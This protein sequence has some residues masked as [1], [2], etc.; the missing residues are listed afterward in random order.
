MVSIRLPN[1]KIIK[2]IPDGTPKEVI[3]QKIVNSG[4]LRAEDNPFQEQQ[5]TSDIFKQQLTGAARD[6]ASFP[7]IIG[8]YADEAEAFAR[9]LVGPETREEELAKIRQ[10]QSQ[11]EDVLERTGASPYR[12]A[13]QIGGSI[14]AGG[15]GLGK[16]G[17]LISKAGP[18]GQAVSKFA[19]T[20]A[21]QSLIGAGIGAIEGAGF[22]DEEAA[23]GGLLG[24]AIGGAVPVVGRGIARAL[25]KTAK[26]AGKPISQ[27]ASTDEGTSA[28]IK[29]IDSSPKLASEIRP[30]AQKGLEE[31]EE[32][33]QRTILDK[34][35]IK[36]IEDIAAPAKKEYGDFINAN[37][38]KQLYDKSSRVVVI[39]KMSE[40]EKLEEAANSLFKVFKKTPYKTKLTPNLE[41]YKARNVRSLARTIRAN[42]PDTFGKMPI[43]SVGFLQELKSRAASKGR[44]VSE[45]AGDWKQASN[46]IKGFID[47]NYP[48]FKELNVK[49]AKATE[50]DKLANRIS[51]LN[52]QEDSNV[53]KSILKGQNK[54]DLYK[55][56]GKEKTN[57]LINALRKE[58]DVR[59]NLKSIASKSRNRAQDRGS[60]NVLLG[61][62]GIGPSIGRGATYVGASSINPALGA[63]IV[64]ADIATGAIVR[65]NA[66]K[67]ARELL[68]GGTKAE[69]NKLANALAAQQIS[70]EVNK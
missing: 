37:A 5:S 43:N 22:G 50:A 35:K 24:G 26:F 34:L 56:F 60:L 13:G 16:L 58:V 18:V 45:N 62:G 48:G 17:S 69:V 59:D 65:R 67:T 52:L 44:S 49:F 1:G 2:G 12:T 42:N 51:N 15:A 47:T 39:P 53:A 41:V 38:S 30:I 32:R 46:K 28:L 54:R 9:S 19:G 61:G 27:V 10:E 14:A 36:K 4:L 40:A 64:G 63:G 8:G 3:K 68:Q 57:N 23:Q 55:S 6:V 31:T 25:G 11:Y 20:K 33:V 7:P 21:G 70:R 29:G 66:A